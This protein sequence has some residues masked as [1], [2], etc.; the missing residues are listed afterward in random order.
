MFK[1]LYYLFTVSVPPG[2][3]SHPLPTSLMHL[4]NLQLQHVFTPENI[5]FQQVASWVLRIIV[6]ECIGQVMGCRPHRARE[7]VNGY[8]FLTH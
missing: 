6:F 1:R 8:P 7:L 3:I 2:G 5:S 4:E